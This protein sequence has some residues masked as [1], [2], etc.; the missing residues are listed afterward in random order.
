MLCLPYTT[1]PLTPAAPDSHPFFLLQQCFSLL[2]SCSALTLHFT[3]FGLL[4][5]QPGTQCQNL[6]PANDAAPSC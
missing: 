6:F 3:S 1:S 4:I 2:A 5:V